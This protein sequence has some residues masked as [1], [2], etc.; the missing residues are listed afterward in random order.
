MLIDNPRFQITLRELRKAKVGK[1]GFRRAICHKEFE[2]Y[3]TA[4][5][6]VG[7]DSVPSGVVNA[8]NHCL[9]QGQVSVISIL[10]R[11]LSLVFQQ[12]KKDISDMALI[13]KFVKWK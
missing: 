4:V 9:H 8:L 11:F 2:A 10:L 5:A 12:P 7:A 13:S 1:A 3:L 6:A